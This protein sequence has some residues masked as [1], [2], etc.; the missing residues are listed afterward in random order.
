MML[1]YWDNFWYFLKQAGWPRVPSAKSCFAGIMIFT[2]S[3]CKKPPV[4]CPSKRFYKFQGKIK[5]IKKNLEE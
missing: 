4:A 5:K 1:C 2:N 3:A